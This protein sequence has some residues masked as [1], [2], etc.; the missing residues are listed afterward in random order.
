MMAT[1]TRRSASLV[2]LSL[3][4]AWSVPASAEPDDAEPVQRAGE[5]RDEDGQAAS[6]PSAT[7]TVPRKPTGRFQIGAGF[8]SDESFIA[9]ATIAQDDLFRTGQR[10]SLT[11]QIS[12][13]RQLFLIG[14]D[15]PLGGGLELRTQ[16]YAADR[17]LPG[18]RRKAAGGT[19]SLVAPL[20]DH[21]TGFFGFRVEHVDAED[22][23]DVIARSVVP[24]SRD[25][26]T[27]A[28][29]RAGIAY[30]TLDQPFLPT[31]GRSFGASVEVAD[32]RW[33]SEVQL[34]RANVWSSYHQELG[35]AILH[36]SA[37]GSAVASK[38]P[39]GVPR[40]ERLYLDSSSLVRGY[41]PGSLGPATGGTVMY[42]ARAELEVPL[43]RS[44]GISAV[45]FLDGGGIFDRSGAGSAGTSYGF[46]LIWRSP[47]GPLRFDW[48]IPI[49]GGPARFV[50]GFGGGFYIAR[51]SA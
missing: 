26:F 10:L 44:A 13:K 9:T 27:L 16:L 29:L 32:P 31:K 47:I 24:E 42:T 49:G 17:L 28:T 43:I 2:A 14:Y 39:L 50:F 51:W 4:M 6:T 35:P 33:G 11:A 45:G 1:Q 12:A 7:A 41:A 23:D 22:T 36:L 38:D 15:V 34:A 19:A 8:S 46:G 5:A 18:F 25:S 3:G 20:G 30:S 48:G 21:L 37:T 40:S